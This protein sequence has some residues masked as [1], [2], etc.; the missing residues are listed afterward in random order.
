[1]LRELQAVDRNNRL[2]ETG[3]RLAALSIDPR[4]GRMLLAAAAENCLD[5]VLTIVAALSI[6]DPRERP[7]DKRQAA[8]E[9]H[10]RWQDKQSDKGN[11]RR[12]FRDPGPGPGDAAR[13]NGRTA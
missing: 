8:D 6:A 12:T 3:R 1:M 7:A 10:R 11:R 5:E 4:F 9:K 2:T 13:G